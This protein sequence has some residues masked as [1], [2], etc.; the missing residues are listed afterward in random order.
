MSH[1]ATHA[2]G[3]TEIAGTFVNPKGMVKK[4]T[5]SAA[6]GTL[7]GVYDGARDV[8]YFGRVGYVAVTANEIALV[9]TKS[10]LLKM[11]I[12]D[13]VLARAERGKLSLVE[14]DA[15]VLLSHLKLKFRDGVM[16]EF[17]VPKASKK[18]AMAVVE[19]LGGTIR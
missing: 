18:T 13:E 2:L 16:W 17:D 6:G 1:D 11:R 14:L 12:S 8:P 5:R 9:K 7:G 10:G 3:A 19:A 15:G 4:M